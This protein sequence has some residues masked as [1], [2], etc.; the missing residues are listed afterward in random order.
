MIIYFLVLVYTFLI[1]YIFLNLIKLNLKM[2]E[3]KKKVK[4][5]YNMK[6][7]E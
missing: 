6:R 5:T 4:S 2:F 1:V 3:K 7:R